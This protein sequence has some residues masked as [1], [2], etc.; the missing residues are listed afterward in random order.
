MNKERKCCRLIDI[1]SDC[2]EIL[3]G[4]KYQKGFKAE[5]NNEYQHGI[6][7]SGCIR[8][9]PITSNTSGL[10]IAKIQKYDVTMCEN[11][12]N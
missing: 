10:F 8:L 12:A 6:D 5:C 2:K 11:K 1:S 4:F 3:K 7:T 9:D